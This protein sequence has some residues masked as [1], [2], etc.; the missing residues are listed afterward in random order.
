MK[1]WQKIVLLALLPLK[2]HPQTGIDFNSAHITDPRTIFNNPAILGF[3]TSR[4]MGVAGYQ[5]FFT[6]LD[7]NLNYSLLGAKFSTQKLGALGV[8]SQIFNSPILRKDDFNFLYSYQIWENKFSVGVNLGWI[9][10]GLEPANFKL[11]Q[12]SDPL[13]VSKNSISTLNLGAGVLYQ[14]L[15]HLYAGLGV[16]HLNHPTLSFDDASE[17]EMSH[18]NISLFYDLSVLKPMISLEREQNRNYFHLGL[19]TWFFNNQTMLRS[20]YNYDNISC[21]LAYRFKNFRLDYE[22]TYLLN[23]L[24]QISNGTHQFL[25][26]YF[27]D[28]ITN[29]WRS[30]ADFEIEVHPDKPK[31]PAEQ[32]IFPGREASFWI[33]ILPENGFNNQ[34]FLSVADLPH[35]F[36]AEL[37]DERIFPVDSALVRFKASSDCPAGN[38]RINIVG[39]SRNLAHVKKIKIKVNPQPEIDA[40][41][42]C[43]PE[44]LKIIKIQEIHEENPL[45]NY[46]FFTENAY[47]L[48]PNRYEILNDRKIPHGFVFF[49]DSVSS[50]QEQYKN[51]LNLIALRLQNWPESKINLIG[52]NADFGVEK[53]NLNL[54]RRRAIAVKNYFTQNCGIDSQRIRI[55]YRNLPEDSSSNQIEEGRTENRRVEILVERESEKILEP[56]TTTSSRIITSDSVCT[57]IMAGTRAVAGV[58]K[59]EVDIRDDTGASIKK[60]DGTGALPDKILWDW[61]T[62]SDEPVFPDK[63]YDINLTIM[64]SLDQVAQ[65]EKT[66]FRTEYEVIQQQLTPQKVEKTRLFLFKFDKD[67]IDV[68]SQRLREKLDQLAVKI[69]AIPGTRVILKGYTDIIGLDDYNRQL[70]IRRANTIRNELIKRGIAESQINALGFGRQN[71]LMDNLLPEGRMMNRRVEVYIEVP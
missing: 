55:S 34:V 71:P 63:V 8:T 3:Q 25:I 9:H 70:S 5:R 21:G 44:V 61:K 4:L 11:L 42:S 51:I 24:N 58:K 49:A 38:F 54:S 30:V 52:C 59:W 39:E 33:Y 62:S 48:D 32:G 15:N 28:R 26:S 41:I 22:Y 18:L 10:V 64:D 56:F 47:R 46:I 40:K 17:K 57:I 53:G 19:E 29:D 2:I 67:Q 1:F 13:L 36:K 68:T 45:L 6:G 35:F 69:S 7:V 12:T 23:E 60:F 37:T 14:P 50:I 20:V 43:R 16:N 65:S 66:T 27:R 31:F